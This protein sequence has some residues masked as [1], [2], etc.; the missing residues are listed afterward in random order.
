MQ[1][2][3]MRVSGARI[4]RAEG[5]VVK[6][7]SSLE[8]PRHAVNLSLRARTHDECVRTAQ[9]EPGSQACVFR[10]RWPLALG[11]LTLLSR[12]A[13][14]AVFAKHGIDT[15]EFDVLATLSRSG[16]PYALRPTELF[17][18]MMISSGGLTDRLRRLEK[19]G[20]IVR[21]ASDEDRRSLIVRLSPRA[22]RSSRESSRRTCAWKRGSSPNSIGASERNW[23]GCSRSCCSTW[24][25]RK[26]DS[27]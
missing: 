4:P 23:R 3:S 27:R 12:P 14:E 25:T 18:T 6:P 8:Q 5:A 2:R 11:A 21:E 20:L 16:P 9:H 24:R 26:A 22:S 10:G 1:A 15:G 13:I 7:N 17:E 19:R